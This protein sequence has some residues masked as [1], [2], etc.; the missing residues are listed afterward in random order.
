[1]HS[2]LRV[3]TKNNCLSFTNMNRFSTAAQ[4]A[5]ANYSK[6]RADYSASVAAFQQKIKT[7]EKENSGSMKKPMAK[8]YE[9]PYNSEHHPLNFSAVKIAETFHDFIGPEQVSPHYESFAMSRKFLLTFWGG[10]FV[11][12]F[13]MATVDL[14]WIMKSTYIPWIFWFQLMYFFVEG[15]N[16][17][18]KPL[19]QRFYRRAAANE[20]FTMEAFY[21]E[22]I[23]NKLRNLMRITKGQLEY[24]DI[25][26]SYS[27]IRADSINNFL[28]NEYL[29]LQSH[30]TNRA[31]N[32]L[33]QAQAYETM[34]QAALLQK[35]IDDATAAIDNALKGDKKAEVL[36]KSL[37]SAIDGIS[38]GYM[39]YQNDP[40]LPL[41]LSSIEAN[42]KKITTLSAQEQ[43]NLI[44]LTAEQLKN[45]KDND[46]R[47]RKEFLESQPKLDNNLKNIESVKKILT[48]WGK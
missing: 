41:I 48:T 6:F 30:I 29:R 17:M 37:D 1:M 25:H 10:F 36:S 8:A 43:A 12:N 42:V 45:I 23:E 19:L 13:G 32:I 33:K 27:E 3:F 21:H 4:V 15:K 5:Q 40:L 14:N 28:A 39:D 47:A 38:K 18:F 24:W 9:H 11:L 44:G 31:L 22:N 34:N 20:I 16:S 26:T 7:I 35:L 2:T 46:V